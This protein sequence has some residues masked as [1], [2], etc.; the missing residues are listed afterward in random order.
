MSNPFEEIWVIRVY[1]DEP[2]LKTLYPSFAESV[3]RIARR[4]VPQDH[5]LI[6]TNY[7]DDLKECS[8]LLVE[9]KKRLPLGELE[10]WPKGCDPNIMNKYK[11]FIQN[12]E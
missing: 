12:K 4:F 5:A 6:L 9:M 7:A 10:Y 8:F 3:N 1:D 2:E 11:E